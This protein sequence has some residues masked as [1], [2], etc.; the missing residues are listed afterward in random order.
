MRTLKRDEARSAF[1]QETVLR[2]TDCPFPVHVYVC[3]HMDTLRKKQTCRAPLSKRKKQIDSN[4]LSE[5]GVA[6]EKGTDIASL[7]RRRLVNSDSLTIQVGVCPRSTCEM[8][9]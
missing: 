4:E 7:R 6:I 8:R 3:T 5:S 2:R 9:M 1:S